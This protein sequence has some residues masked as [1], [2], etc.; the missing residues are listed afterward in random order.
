MPEGALRYQNDYASNVRLLRCAT[1]LAS[2]DLLGIVTFDQSTYALP[3]II[4]QQSVSR[5]E[6][7][8]R[9]ESS[10]NGMPERSAMSSS[11]CSPSEDSE[12]KAAH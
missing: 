3:T 5:R 6:V 1:A 2:V 12:P 7:P 11:E 4:S 9:R 8:R 10:A